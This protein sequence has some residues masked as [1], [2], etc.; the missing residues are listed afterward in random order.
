MTCDYADCY[1]PPSRHHECAAK[2]LGKCWGRLEHQ[3]CPRRSQTPRAERQVP[4]LLCS[5]H[6]HAV[7]Q[8]ARYEGL[9]IADRIQES[10]DWGVEKRRKRYEIYDRGSGDILVSIPLAALDMGGGETGVGATLAGPLT[11]PSVP[12]A[13]E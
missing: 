11:P 10:K 8:G 12:G 7:D 2:G 9:R 3:H 5:G 4:V 6:H 1:V 13:S